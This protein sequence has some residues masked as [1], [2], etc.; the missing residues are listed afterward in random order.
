[1]P[2]LKPVL[3][4]LAAALAGLL[5]AAP[6]Q[7]DLDAGVV[8]DRP[9]VTADGGAAFFAL[10]NDVGL[11]EI[12]ITVQWDPARPT[13]IE[14][15]A[16][17]ASMLPVATLRG[18]R[19]VF[20]VQPLKARSVTG[21]PNGAQQFADFVAQVATTFPTVKD[22][23][24][25][26]EPNL[27]RFWAPQFT[28]GGKSVSTAAYADLLARSYDA[29]KAV[30]P[31]NNV[32][33]LGLSPRGNDLP[34]APGNISHS[35]VKFLN[36][37]GKAYRASRRSRPL[38]DMFAF[39]PYPKTDRDPLAKGYPWPNAG[40][41]NLGRIKQAFYDAFRGTAQKTFEQGLKMKLDEV[42]W[43]VGV[44]ASAQDSY[45][46]AE[47]I[48][49]TDEATQASIYAA[50][51]RQ[52][53]CDPSV[54]SVLFFGFEDE[55]DL[56]RWQSG[57]MRADGSP[58]ASYHSVKATLAQT[59]GRC[60]GRMQGWKHSLTLEGVSAQFPKLGRLPSRANSWS[61]V[62]RAEEDALFDAGIHRFNGRRGARVLTA[63]GQLE[64][65]KGRLVRLPSRRLAPGRY[66]FSIR[67]RATM[68]PARTMRL[69]GR[70]FTVY[71]AR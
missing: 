43:Q 28:S 31:T 58:R 54:Q 40:I 38:M 19:V 44:V 17:V 57:L 13:T 63:T 37:L 68:N 66:V 14:N 23:I 53:A 4:L 61:L 11:K 36:G 32:I 42:G 29:L 47:S 55:P 16:Y 10:M 65:H 26:N 22:F 50:L 56:D 6:A 51:L 64:G 39:H 9:V 1:M 20:S 33:G 41:P 8:D 67:F 25:G 12:R 71:R 2:R 62:A 5:L 15:Q 49:P 7:A 34:N 45:F 3:T 46:G 69:T 27:S 60:T 21:T 24:I 35:P 30:S 18:M 48:K 70:P 52:V 59:G